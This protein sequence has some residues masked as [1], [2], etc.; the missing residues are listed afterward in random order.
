MRERNDY[1]PFENCSLKFLSIVA[2]IAVAVETILLLL[3]LLLLLHII[4]N[5]AGNT[6]YIHREDI[7]DLSSNIL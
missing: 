1:E 2:N 7:T 6:K 3:L 4:I 5:K